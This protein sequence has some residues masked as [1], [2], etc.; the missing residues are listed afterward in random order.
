V[1]DLHRPVIRISGHS[2]IPRFL[3]PESVVVDLGL[4]KG[5]FAMGIIRTFLCRVFGVEPVPE[6]FAKLPRHKYFAALPVA[7]GERNARMD[8][9]LFHAQCA[10]LFEEE[11]IE[12]VDTVSVESVTLEEFLSRFDLRTVDLLKIDVEGAEMGLLMAARDETF[13]RIGQIT[14]EFHDFLFPYMR[15]QAREVMKRLIDLG[16]YRINFSMDN[17]DVLFVN[18][19]LLDVGWL[20]YLYLKYIVKY[21]KGCARVA[22][23]YWLGIFDPSHNRLIING[24]WIS[25]QLCLRGATPRACHARRP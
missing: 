2:F 8:L 16:F 20:E 9:N 11:N 12:K 1:I 14:V 21:Y 13:G 7:V 24:C 22:R 5:E 17:T 3:G 15:T 10:S 18:R 19:Y 6:L 23:R 4:H 25:R